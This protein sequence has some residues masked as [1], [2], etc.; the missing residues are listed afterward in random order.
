M[1]GLVTVEVDIGSVLWDR[2]ASHSFLVR[3]RRG[4]T[5]EIVA[6]GLTRDCAETLAG[7]LALI[8]A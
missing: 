7:R 3:I 4:D 2:P 1:T 5:Y 6:H 8:L